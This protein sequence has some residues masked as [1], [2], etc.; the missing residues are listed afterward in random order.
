MKISTFIQPDFFFGWFDGTP[1]AVLFGAQHALQNGTA[2]FI[3]TAMR[4]KTAMLVRT[5]ILGRTALLKK[6]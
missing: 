2:M 1:A 5:A 3:R 4:I 6:C